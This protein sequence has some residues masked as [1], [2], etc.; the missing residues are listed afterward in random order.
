MGGQFEEQGGG[1]ELEVNISE[2]RVD[3]EHTTENDEAEVV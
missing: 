1:L 3:M 2:E